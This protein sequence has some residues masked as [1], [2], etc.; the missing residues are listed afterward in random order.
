MD[1]CFENLPTDL[2]EEGL[3]K[4]VGIF[5]PPHSVKIVRENGV[6]RGF[7]FVKVAEDKANDVITG[8]NKKLFEGK[9]LI[10]RKAYNKSPHLKSLFISKKWREKAEEKG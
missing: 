5:A 9:N 4:L 7:G 2:D 6:S 10:V 8:L 1:L 3:R